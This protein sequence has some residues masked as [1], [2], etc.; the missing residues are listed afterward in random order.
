MA[1]AIPVILT[2]DCLEV[3]L[4]GKGQD[5]LA[6]LKCRLASG[7][8]ALVARCNRMYRVITSAGCV[9][10]AAR[11][12]NHRGGSDVTTMGTVAAVLDCAAGNHHRRVLLQV[13]RVIRTTR[14][15]ELRQWVIKE[16]GSLNSEL[17]AL[18]F[19]HL[20]RL[21]DTQV[22]VKVS[23]CVEI[24]P[25]ERANLPKR[26]GSEAVGVKVGTASMVLRIA[27]NQRNHGRVTTASL[28]C[29]KPSRLVDRG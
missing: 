7:G 27:G 13:D 15:T 5:A 8:C 14:Q 18:A 26:R 20:E 23:R 2:D 9:W 28:R 11:N 10:A 29:S 19:R 4:H 16:V 17:Q 24:R 12:G 25:A 22:A 3:E 1:E 6:I 21:V